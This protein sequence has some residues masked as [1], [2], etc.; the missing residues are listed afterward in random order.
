[1][2][3][4]RVASPDICIHSLLLPELKQNYSEI[5]LD[6]PKTG[7]WPAQTLTSKS[8]Q[9]TSRSVKMILLENDELLLTMLTESHLQKKSQIENPNSIFTSNSIVNHIEQMEG[10]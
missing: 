4:G 5:R 9:P 2:K 7:N 6:T 3:Y 8:L 1:M 10:Q